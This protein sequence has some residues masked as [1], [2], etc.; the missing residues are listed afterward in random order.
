MPVIRTPEGSLITHI[1]KCEAF[2][3]QFAAVGREVASGRNVG[4]LYFEVQRSVAMI[5]QL[6]LCP[7]EIPLVTAVDVASEIKCLNA[8]KAPGPDCVSNRHLKHL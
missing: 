2:A 1:E 6:V 7:E 3:E 4:S 8:N 5:D